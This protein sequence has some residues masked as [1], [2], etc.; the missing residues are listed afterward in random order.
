MDIILKICCN[1]RCCIQEL[2]DMVKTLP[3]LTHVKVFFEY[4]YIQT[5][6]ECIMFVSQNTDYH[7]L[8]GQFF[9]SVTTCGKLSDFELYY[10][11]L[12]RIR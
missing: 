8:Y 1:E 4:K 11:A 3:D 7:N 6:T 12:T 2:K 10:F 9:K 5:P